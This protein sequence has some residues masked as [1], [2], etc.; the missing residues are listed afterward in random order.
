MNWS[1]I[2]RAVTCLHGRQR[3]SCPL[4]ILALAGVMSFAA[5]CEQPRRPLPPPAPKPT[6]QQRTPSAKPSETPAES[7]EQPSAKSDSSPTAPTRPGDSSSEASEAPQTPGV[8]GG[9]GASRPAPPAPAAPRFSTPEAAS[10][11]AAEKFA[12]AKESLGDDDAQGA[13]QEA[14]EGW[15]ALQPHLDNPRCQQLADELTTLMKQSDQSMS[16]ADELLDRP[17]MIK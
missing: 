17:L 2:K 7:Q 13:F 1:S 15:Q 8:G 4:P 6:P 14:L 5:G 11:F 12:E 16:P 9:N 3:G 10:R